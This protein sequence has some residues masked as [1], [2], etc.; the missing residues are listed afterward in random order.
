MDPNAFRES[1][2]RA[3]E[4]EALD[5]DVSKPGIQTGTE[6]EDAER[7]DNT[8][9]AGFLERVAIMLVV[10]LVGAVILWLTLRP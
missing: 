1:D 2:Q 6:P 4:L 5:T 3:A 9:A 8:W 7:A 10:V